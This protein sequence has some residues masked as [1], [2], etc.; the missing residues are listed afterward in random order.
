MKLC[1]KAEYVELCFY[2]SIKFGGLEASKCG[3]VP[4]LQSNSRIKVIV[5]WLQTGRS[6]SSVTF[7]LFF[8]A[9]V[10]VKNLVLFHCT[11]TGQ[12]QCRVLKAPENPATSLNIFPL[13]RPLTK[14]PGRFT[15]W[16]SGICQEQK[17][18]ELMLK[19]RRFSERGNSTK[20]LL[21]FHLQQQTH[22]KRACVL[23]PQY[24]MSRKSQK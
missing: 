2:L 6:Q 5:G 16:V 4:A 24:C 20:V 11:Y 7:K 13:Q 17:I 1:R 18:P 8:E 12:G 23:Y 14:D 22:T 21:N 15:R 9:E 10:W 19:M 3:S